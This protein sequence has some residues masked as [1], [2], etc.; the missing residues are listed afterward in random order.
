MKT[1]L[2]STVLVLFLVGIQTYGNAQTKCNDDAYAGQEWA[3]EWDTNFGKLVLTQKGSKVSGTYKNVG[4]IDAFYNKLTGKLKG[5]FTNNGKKGSFEFTFTSCE[6]FSGKWGWGTSM[7]KGRWTGKRKGVNNP[8]A[9]LQLKITLNGIRALQG[10]DGKG[11]PDDYSLNFTPELITLNKRQTLRNKAFNFR[12]SYHQ[13]KTKGNILFSSGSGQ[14]HIEPDYPP[15]RKD[16]ST[17][18]KKYAKIE[19][20]GQFR[21]ARSDYEKSRIKMHIEFSLLENT[22]ANI[23]TR[24]EAPYWLIKNKKVPVNI[25]L[26]LD[27]LTG[28][29]TRA[30]VEASLNE[31]LGGKNVLTFSLLEKNGI[32]KAKGYIVVQT[33][34]DRQTY[35]A[36]VPFTLELVN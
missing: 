12:K 1:I 30:Q 36:G 15:T 11:N 33:T 29:K 27:Y 26:V 23:L 21:I 31:F 9:P 13:N 24:P 5:T 7:D 8:A 28:L 10:G 35:K 16:R 20:S 25:K 18:P 34:E 6:G 3:G 14:I 17:N 19:N 2:K 32:R 4:K 22:T